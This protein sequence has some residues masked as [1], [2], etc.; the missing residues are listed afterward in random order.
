MGLTD[1]K[2]IHDLAVNV[3]QN[4][5]SGRRL[6]KKHLSATRER[7]DVGR[8]SRKEFNNALGERALSSNI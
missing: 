5:Y 6:T 4:F 8:V 1:A 3:V 2:E 7:F